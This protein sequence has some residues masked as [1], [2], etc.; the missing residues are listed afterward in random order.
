MNK[1]SATTP[2]TATLVG[3]PTAGSFTGTGCGK[4]ALAIPANTHGT[5]ALRY[6]ADDRT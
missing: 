4:V 5:L 6:G 3:I 1:A 2:L